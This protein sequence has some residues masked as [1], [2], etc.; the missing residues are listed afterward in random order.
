MPD[1]YE[2]VAADTLRDVEELRPKRKSPRARI[3]SFA[4]R[5]LER[6]PDVL[7]FLDALDKTAQTIAGQ[8]VLD[9][10]QFIPGEQSAERAFKEQQGLPP[11]KRI[12]PYP[13]AA[14]RGAFEEQDFPSLNL[15]IARHPIPL[16]GGKSLQQVDIGVKGAIEIATDPLIIAG[17]IGVGL[18]AP[19]KVL[20]K[21][22]I[23]TRAALSVEEIAVN[24]KMVE[25]IKV[26]RPVRAETV[27]A[28][29]QVLAEKTS[30]GRAALGSKDLTGTER[31]RGLG[32]AFKG[33]M[34]TADRITPLRAS[35]KGQM[36]K[37]QNQLEG[38]IAD[39]F[40]PE[41]LDDPYLAL[42]A[43]SG[44]KKLWTKGEIPTQSE[45][46]A[47]E[48]VFGP[49]FGKAASGAF[50]S[51]WSR[52]LDLF[53]E[54]WNVPKSMVA[55]GDISASFRQA[56]PFILTNKGEPYRNAFVQQLKA[57]NSAEGA[58]ASA[59]KIRSHEWYNQIVE[60]GGL[61]LT[62]LASG[63]GLSRGAALVAREEPFLG[64]R[65]A[66]KI[67]IYGNLVRASERAYVTMLNEVRFYTAVA[68]LEKLGGKATLKQV[69]DISKPINILSGRSTLGKFQ[70]AGA[71]LNGVFFAP[72]FAVS[73][74]Q[75]FT[76]PFAGDAAARKLTAQALAS[77][78]GT[79]LSMLALA[80]L[81]GVGKVEWID[82]RSSDFLKLRFGNTRIDPWAGLQQ[83]VVLAARL[84]TGTSKTI[85][86]GDL[87]GLNAYDAIARFFENKLSPSARAL[88][89]RGQGFSGEAP[90]DKSPI[91]YMPRVAFDNFV[92]LFVQDIAEAMKEHGP[93]G[94][95]AVAAP[96][97]LGLGVQTFGASMSEFSREWKPDFAPYYE[98]KSTEAERKAA[99]QRKSR[100]QYRKANPRMDAELF[101]VGKVKTLESGAAKSHALRLIVEHDL[102]S[103]RN[104]E[105]E[106]LDT[107]KKVLGR[108]RIE[109]L[110]EA[111]EAAEA[112]SASTPWAEIS[113]LLQS[114]DFIALTKAWRGATLSEMETS[115]L[116]KVF[117]RYPLGQTDFAMW[118]KALQEVQAND[119]VGR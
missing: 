15:P 5:F 99:G 119:A 30:A 97:V 63:K 36:K 71:I 64:A 47:L 73:R 103:K 25:A 43:R 96:A 75:T 59:L 68:E 11:K 74:F 49:E 93:G 105:P 6:T 18:K 12:D 66:G 48:E 95:A 19:A 116:K 50:R 17:G 106:L 54:V 70:N 21:E 3:N 100:D 118:L 76:M 58:A 62:E 101:L 33:E 28:A 117:V 115:R 80:D 37:T 13:F 112:V 78:A 42:S 39:T 94:A 90:T 107:W 35:F 65:I 110:L 86:E 55:A 4:A 10:Q 109:A 52:A 83:P 7:D 60:R 91:P 38:R 81:S 9:I 14:V 111:A 102:L 51:K 61:D 89:N 23:P 67:P 57:W 79:V 56:A 104:L 84:A 113:A 27:L 98:I 53:I 45:L 2:T 72:R 8:V 41:R 24:A 40:S 34:P 22:A 26:A 85:P 32:A 46:S 87:K 16:P 114:S 92:F 82:P 1:P 77:Y 29:R 31:L 88:L 69:K 108:G 44:F 20:V